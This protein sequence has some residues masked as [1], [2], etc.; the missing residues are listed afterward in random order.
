MIHIPFLTNR[1]FIT[2]RL[3]LDY[4]I[5]YKEGDEIANK[6]DIIFKEGS[7]AE[8][9]KQYQSMLYVSQTPFYNWLKPVLERLHNEPAQNTDILLSWIKEIDN[10]LHTLPKDV[11]EMTYDNGIDR[12]WFWRLDYYLWER[13]EDYFDSEEDRQIV[14][15]YV[16]RANRSIEHLHPQHQENNDVWDD[17][18]IHSFGNLA[19]ISQSFNSQQSDDPVTVKFARIMDQAHNH[20]LQSIKMYLMYLDAEKSPSGWK[21]DI[22]NDHQAK[23]YELLVKS[24]ELK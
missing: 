23:M 18:D 13:K 7:S 14:E 10:S 6:Y 9:L 19:M 22:K 8:A 20:A 12:Y 15:E 16:F 17:G 5:V 11:S 2:N 3:L 21:V 1:T 4:Y 24:Y